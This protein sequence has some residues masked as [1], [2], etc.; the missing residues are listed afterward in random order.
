MLVARNIGPVSLVRS[1]KNWHNRRS[2]RK[3]ILRIPPPTTSGHL[4]V[5]LANF[6]A[7]KTLQFEIE[8]HLRWGMSQMELDTFQNIPVL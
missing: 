1:T 7:S 6:R 8:V 2:G 4:A 5:Y 3:L